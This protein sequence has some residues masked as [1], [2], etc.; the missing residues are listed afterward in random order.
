MNEKRGVALRT[1]GVSGRNPLPSW[2]NTALHIKKK[3]EPEG[4]SAI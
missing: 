2:E 1:V 3:S 4:F